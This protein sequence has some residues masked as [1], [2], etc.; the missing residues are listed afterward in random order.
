MPDSP[1]ISKEGQGVVYN[2]IAFFRPVQPEFL[3][4]ET[5]STQRT[6]KKKN[7]ICLCDLCGFARRNK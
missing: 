6:E 4:A 2:N 1:P 7:L 5:Q 3:L